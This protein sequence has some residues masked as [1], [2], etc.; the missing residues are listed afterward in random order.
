MLPNGP[1]KKVT[2]PYSSDTRLCTQDTAWPIV[3]HCSAGIGRTGV[4]MLIDMSLAQLE[5]GELTDP[6]VLLESIRE[7]RYG[8]VQTPDQFA[9]CYQV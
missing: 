7:Q 2:H 5:A 8:L 1:L 9:F 6:V 3:V 4:C